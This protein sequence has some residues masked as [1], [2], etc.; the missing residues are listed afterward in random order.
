MSGTRN[1]EAKIIRILDESNEPLRAREI[2]AILNVERDEVN[3]H[4]NS[5]LRDFVVQGTGWR[6]SLVPRV[7]NLKSKIFETVQQS[8]YPIRAREVGEQ[9]GV[10]R[11]IVNHYL[12]TTLRT[13]V[14]QDDQWR[15]IV[16]AQNASNASAVRSSAQP[17]PRASPPTTT[18]Q[19]SVYSHV[20][21]T[22][23][24]SSR[25]AAASTHPTPP[26]P[27][28][29]TPPEPRKEK[30]PIVTPPP[31]PAVAKAQVEGRKEDPYGT[32]L[33]QLENCSPEEKVA[34]IEQAFAQDRFLELNNEEM[35]AL[36][37]VLETA[38]VLVEASKA[39]QK[40]QL[41]YQR[42]RIITGVAVAIAFIMGALL[43]FT[44]F[45]KYEPGTTSPNPEL[46]SS[47]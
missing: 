14:Q 5:S 40:K 34:I 19:P 9:L 27:A 7:Q 26:K 18:R 45:S 36:A 25:P 31:K 30:P 1:L 42:Q 39:Q 33:R 46:P 41:S 16:I 3:H 22:S 6:W 35:G 28:A 24:R 2:A 12:F 10:P 29:S 47:K 37:S 4:L 43:L 32:I 15:W 21:S 8:T 11:N 44:Q 17:E 20:Y 13:Q 23:K 38:K